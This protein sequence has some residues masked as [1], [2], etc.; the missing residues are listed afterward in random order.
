[1]EMLDKLTYPILHFIMKH[2]GTLNAWAWR[3]HV[4]IIETKRQKGQYNCYKFM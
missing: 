1:M 3:K 4:K 2:A